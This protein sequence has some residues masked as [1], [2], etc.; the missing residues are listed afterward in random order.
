MDNWDW[1]AGSCQVSKNL[2]T[3]SRQCLSFLLSTPVA[4]CQHLRLKSIH[5]ISRQNREVHVAE[6][7]FVLLE[8]P[9]GSF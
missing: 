8:A 4:L 2:R 7:K 3:Y 9:V 6:V 5:L 1:S